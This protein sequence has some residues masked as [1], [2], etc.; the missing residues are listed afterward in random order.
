MRGISRQEAATM[1][2][3]PHDSASRLEAGRSKALGEKSSSGANFINSSSTPGRADPTRAPA[4]RMS[5][6]GRL[7]LTILLSLLVTFGLASALSPGDWHHRP[8]QQGED[9][10]R[11]DVRESAGDGAP[12]TSL[13]EAASPNSLHEL[14][15]KYFPERFKDGVW[16]T[17][18]S[19]VEAVRR[20]D[21]ALA[22]SIVQLAK[23][24]DNGTATTPSTT[25]PTPTPP[26]ASST[27]PPNDGSSTDTPPP[28]SSVPPPPSSSPPGQSSTPSTSRTEPSSSTPPSSSATMTTSRSTTPPG[29]SSSADTT[30]PSSSPLASSSPTSSPPTSSSTHGSTLVTASHSAPLTTASIARGGRLQSDYVSWCCYHLLHRVSHLAVVSAMA[31]PLP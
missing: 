5:A 23:R 18:A 4:E 24:A 3:L 9:V 20:V 21:A 2:P 7:L 11:Q 29:T 6:A 12:F 13:L 14:L 8:G 31:P 28:T 16:E 26:P 17:D 22:T 25:T 10:V 27:P 1:A 19:A 30:E 15:H